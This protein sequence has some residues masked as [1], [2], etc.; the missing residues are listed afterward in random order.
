MSPLQ[1]RLPSSKGKCSMWCTYEIQ[2][3]F[4]IEAGLSAS[5]IP[6]HTVSL[7]LWTCWW[8]SRNFFRLHTISLGPASARPGP[9]PQHV[10]Q[11]WN[12]YRTVW[13]ELGWLSH[14][15]TQG[16]RPHAWGL[17]WL[18]E[19]RVPHRMNNGKRE[20]ECNWYVAYTFNYFG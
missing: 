13:P 6:C 15:T 2:H 9:M 17:V 7:E 1:F 16:M 5:Y 8:S 3:H 18:W 20:I 12:L 14:H 19:N 11:E 10:S 4:F